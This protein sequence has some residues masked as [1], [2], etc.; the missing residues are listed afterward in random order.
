MVADS[1]T[2]LDNRLLFR[3]KLRIS[4]IEG[5]HHEGTPE[6]DYPG[7]VNIGSKSPLWKPS[8]DRSATT[9]FYLGGMIEYPSQ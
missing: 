4:L 8:R 1:A 7:G 5:R 2:L 6:G 9:R 3:Y